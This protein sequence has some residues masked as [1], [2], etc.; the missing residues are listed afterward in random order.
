MLHAVLRGK[1]DPANPEPQNLEDALTSTVFGTLALAGAWRTLAA[2]LGIEDLVGVAADT[3]PRLWFWPQLAGVEPDVLISFGATLVSIEAKYRS[4]R[5]DVAAMN[6]GGED[7]AVDQ[8]RRQY[9]A[10]AL[11]V[12]RRRRYSEPIE[13]A[14]AQREGLVQVFLVDARRRRRAA[15]E[16]DESKS[17]L[18]IGAD[19]RF[20]T[21]QELY[22]FL[23]T[24]QPGPERWRTDLKSYFDLLLLDTFVGIKT[25]LASAAESGTLQRWRT[26]GQ[27]A[28][29][30]D[31][32]QA[33]IWSHGAKAIHAWQYEAAT[34]EAHWTFD[35]AVIDGSCARVLSH[36]RFEGA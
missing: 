31:T 36:W 10:I 29:F 32:V 27:V 5:H 12:H 6:V 7:R 15:R 1:L 4:N 24:A 28:R 17:L 19:L 23:V 20:A 9:D 8:L 2:W 21:W 16:Y 35:G 14:I 34:V 33:F 11:P 3:E 30:A 22:R 26:E 18:P 13:E 25:N